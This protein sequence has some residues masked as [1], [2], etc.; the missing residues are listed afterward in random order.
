MKK[1]LSEATA[2]TVQ[3]SAESLS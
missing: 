1:T 3:I 2:M